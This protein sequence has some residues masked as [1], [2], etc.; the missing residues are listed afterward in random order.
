MNTKSIIFL[1]LVVL[2]ALALRIH[3]ETTTETIDTS[4]SDTPSVTQNQTESESA[5]YVREAAMLEHRPVLREAIVRVYRILTNRVVG[6]IPIPLSATDGLSI[7]PNHAKVISLLQSA[8]DAE[9]DALKKAR[10]LELLTQCKSYAGETESSGEVKGTQSTERKDSRQVDNDSENPSGSRS[11]NDQRGSSPSTSGIPSA[12]PSVAGSE[13]PRTTQSGLEGQ[14]KS[15]N[16]GGNDSQQSG[17]GVSGVVPGIPSGVNLPTIGTDLYEQPGKSGSATELQIRHQ[18]HQFDKFV[19][20]SEAANRHADENN[21]SQISSSESGA[22]VA[23]NSSNQPAEEGPASDSKTKLP[24]PW[25]SVQE[26]QAN[27]KKD[28]R[29]LGIPITAYPPISN[30]SNANSSTSGT[31]SLVE[32]DVARFLREAIEAETDP[33]KKAELQAEYDAYMKNR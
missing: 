23:S 28:K 17:L 14:T 21:K 9:T 20:D 31:E 25:A 3:G 19:S 6:P 30:S 32:D 24:V 12:S 29:I 26:K 27:Q 11:G 33:E 22:P 4:L 5:R 13:L 2:A 18:L 10:L 7:L 16:R 15:N 1:S 8:I